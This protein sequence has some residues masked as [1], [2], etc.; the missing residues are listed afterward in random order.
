MILPHRYD[1]LSVV[2]R[3]E[4]MMTKIQPR[5]HCAWFKALL[6][7]N[8]LQRC[9]GNSDS[10][11]PEHLPNL[12]PHSSRTGDN[13]TDKTMPPMD[14]DDKEKNKRRSDNELF[15]KYQYILWID[16]DAVIIDHDKTVQSFL[17]QAVS[18]ECDILISEDMGGK[19][20]GSTCCPINTGTVK[21]RQYYM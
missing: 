18:D 21:P 8:I 6:I 9:H 14:D 10:S 19:E 3:F 16:A 2:M 1:F 12:T 13:S 20:G 15:S 4:D 17:Q 5:Q 11:A 7:L